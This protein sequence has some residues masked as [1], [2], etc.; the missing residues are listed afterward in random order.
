MAKK[1]LAQLFDSYLN[2]NIECAKKCA[3]LCLELRQN[4]KTMANNDTMAP[5][6][7]PSF[8]SYCLEFV[9]TN[10]TNA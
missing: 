4:T 9:S 2:I 1:M 5:I 8:T 6:F 7:L 10:S 3:C